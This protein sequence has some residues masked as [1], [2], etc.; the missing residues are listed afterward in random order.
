MNKKGFTILEIVITLSLIATVAL[1]FSNSFDNIEHN[2]KI[3]ES[4]MFLNKIYNATNIYIDSNPAVNGFLYK[5]GYALF[6]VKKLIDG[7]YL[8]E[9]IINPK[10]NKKINQDEYIYIY[11]NENSV[12]SIDYPHL[13]PGKNECYLYMEP[14]YYDSRDSYDSVEE[15]AFYNI[16]SPAFHLRNTS[17]TVITSLTKNSNIA[18]VDY[19]V[20]LSNS[21]VYTI[22]YKYKDCFNSS[23]WRKATRIIIKE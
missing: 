9:N 15:L 5:G 22:T 17:N 12:I 4:K 6:Q 7:G 10:T 11:Y 21:G 13:N 14:F 16:N 1:L 23:V 19:D 2:Q 20:D 3:S 18:L 8:D